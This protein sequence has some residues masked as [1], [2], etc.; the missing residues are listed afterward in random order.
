MRIIPVPAKLNAP[1]TRADALALLRDFLP[2][3]PDYAG[4]R[5]H[6]GPSGTGVSGLSAAITHRLITE[7]E[8][9]GEV[10]SAHPFPKAEKFVQEVLWRRYWKA[11]L[12]W[13]P[14][15]WSDWLCDVADLPR[16]PRVAMVE[17]GESGVAVMDAFVRQLIE[18]G[19]LHNHVRMWF[20]AWW[21]HVERLPWQLGAAFFMRH[22]LD[23]DAASNTLSWRWVA[24]LQTAGKT[25]LPR[26]SNL[27][28]WLDRDWLD[29]HRD[30]IECLEN[31]VAYEPVGG[32]RPTAHPPERSAG[33][34]AEPGYLL[35]IH[36]EDLSLERLGADLP[37]PRAV[38][39]GASGG[40]DGGG[41]LEITP[42]RRSWLA[43]ALNDAATRAEKAWG[44]P[45][46]VQ[47]Y[48]SFPDEFAGR[49]ADMARRTQCGRV[50]ASRPFV[51]ALADRAGAIQRR[52]E[53]KGVGL[54]FMDLPED[55]EWLPL[56]RRGF[57]PFWKEARKRVVDWAA[58]PG[59][60]GV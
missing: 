57:F 43:S 4:N 9:V 30:G 53:E 52:L 26:L 18:A 11:W 25:Y 60:G 38:W 34:P 23:G 56:G 58:A 37:P 29:R 14:S 2:R 36:E 20:A 24:G 55:A 50:V 40:P 10:L 35:W 5:N 8:V 47:S 44:V 7:R 15:V 22:L 48:L 33:F 19:Y 42:L 39:V 6:A 3:I 51:G 49:L 28:R 16:S 17:G 31:P 54:Y 41:L 46:E 45:V 12:E 1:A 27:E 59:A 21:V 13:H 32:E